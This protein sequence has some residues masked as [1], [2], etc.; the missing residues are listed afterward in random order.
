LFRLHKVPIIGKKDLE[1]KTLPR[2]HTDVL[3]KKDQV[4]VG[5]KDNR[6][7]YMAS[8]KCSPDADN[9]CRRFCRA[10]RK[11]VQVPIPA[12]VEAYNHGMGGVDLI[13]NMVACYR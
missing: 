2:G 5:W 13:D 8:N 11:S 9:H 6:G 10:E 12:L 1:K 4:L 7:V 3:F